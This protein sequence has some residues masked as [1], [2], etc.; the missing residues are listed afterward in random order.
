MMAPPSFTYAQ[1]YAEMP[2]DLAPEYEGFYAR[3]ELQGTPAGNRTSLQRI[4]HLTKDIPRVYL[5]LTTQ[6][7]DAG[8]A[9]EGGFMVRVLHRVTSYTPG[10]HPGPYDDVTFGFLGDLMTGNHIEMIRVPPSLMEPTD[11]TEVPVLPNMATAVL[12]LADDRHLL[13]P[14]STEDAADDWEKVQVTKMIPVPPCYVPL[15]MG[16]DH[17]PL[18]LW[19]ELGGAILSEGTAE[20]HGPLL[21]WL[22]VSA[23]AT[24]PGVTRAA[25]E[26]PP[27][28]A[29][30]MAALPPLRVDEALQTFRWRILTEDFPQLAAGGAAPTAAPAPDVNERLLD[31]LQEERGRRA[32]AAEAPVQKSPAAFTESVE[33][34]QKLAGGCTVQE[35]P[36]IYQ[37]MAKSTK[38]VGLRM[39][40]EAAFQQ[41][42]HEDTAVTARPPLATRELTTAI[43]YAKVAPPVHDVANLLEGISPLNCGAFP[44]HARRRDAEQRIVEYDTHMGGDTQLTL[45]ESRQLTSNEIFW[46]SDRLQATTM[47]E[48]CSIVLDE[49]QGA[50]HPHARVFRRFVMS[51]WR[52]VCNVLVGDALADA[53]PD[54]FGRLLLAISRRMSAYFRELFD[55]DLE[56]IADGRGPRIP[57]YH[58]IPDRVVDGDHHL[59]PDIPAR[60]RTSN[61]PTTTGGNNSAPPATTT[62][63]SGG[64]GTNP[65]STTG[66]NRTSNRGVNNEANSALMRRFRDGNLTLA[67][68]ST[69]RP[70]DPATGT[71]Y[72]L[73]WQFRGRCRGCSRIHAPYS[74]LSQQVRSQLNAGVARAL[75]ARDDG[76]AAADSNTTAT[77]A[78]PT[79]TP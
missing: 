33:R 42:C 75:A 26:G 41:R 50:G 11:A 16:R 10:T 34:F 53:G 8:G 20:H 72:C 51:D 37:L 65:P 15:V 49:L 59:L 57:S 76:T 66:G 9:T 61:T 78:P 25:Q 62:A 74:E 73:N 6:A 46:P 31:M 77:G 17:T 35:L 36:R 13:P 47:L 12:Q 3:F 1:A 60:W 7:A 70:T 39:A 18:S 69:V 68:L 55:M 71:E 79:D 27:A 38:G 58:N 4:G 30:G 32:A 5:A 21:D 19:T 40:V 63:N 64:G 52:T 23:T 54:I 43:R 2:D 29:L 24:R 48:S 67:D 28:T 45:A 22:R 14:K 56:D 44:D